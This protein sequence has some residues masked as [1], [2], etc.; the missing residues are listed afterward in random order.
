MPRLT[1]LWHGSRFQHRI[2]S[3]PNAT[4]FPDLALDDVL[5]L[6]WVNL[7]PTILRLTPIYDAGTVRTVFEH[8]RW[9]TTWPG[10]SLG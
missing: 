8:A 7:T 5:V 3:L 9:S 6:D 10:A 4:E 1:R 2:G